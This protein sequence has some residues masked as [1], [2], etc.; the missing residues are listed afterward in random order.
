MVLPP[1]LKEQIREL[2]IKDAKAERNR[3]FDL[4][5]KRK[6]KTLAKKQA[7]KLREK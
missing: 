3:L 7:D 1:K 4:H 5:Q 6:K 2:A